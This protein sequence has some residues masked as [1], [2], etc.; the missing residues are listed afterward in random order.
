MRTTSQIPQWDYSKPSHKSDPEDMNT[1]LPL[2]SFFELYLT[3]K[4]LNE[5]KYNKDW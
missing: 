3:V 4:F 5:F 2:L 1:F